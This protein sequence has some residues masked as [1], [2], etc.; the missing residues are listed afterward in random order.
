MTLAGTARGLTYYDLA[1]VGTGTAPY[2][3][4]AY[5]YTDCPGLGG[6]LIP[7]TQQTWASIPADGYIYILSADFSDSPI[8][9][10]NTLWMIVTFSSADAGWVVADR[11]ETGSTQ[12]LYGQKDPLWVC[13][14]WF[15]G[16]P[17]DYAGFWA[18]I[19]CIDLPEPQGAC[20][21]TDHTCTYGTIS[22]CTAAGGLFMGEGTTCAGVNCA[23]LNVGACCNTINWSC[24]L[25]TAADCAAAGGSFDG[26]GTS[27][28]GAC[29]E[30]R[31]EINPVTLSYNPGRPMAEDLTLAGTA[32]DLSYFSIAVYGGGG[33]AFNL[34]TAF[35]TA[36]PCSGGTMIPGT[37][38]SGSGLPDGQVLN[39]T[40]TLP[41][42]VT[43]PNNPWLVME[44]STAYA[45]WIVA[46]TAEVGSTANT[47]GLAQYDGQ[48]WTWTCNNTVSDAYGGF[49][50]DVQCIDASKSGRVGIGP[51]I[52]EVTPVPTPP[53]SVRLV[54]P[55]GENRPVPAA[56]LLTAP[57]RTSIRRAPD[58]VQVS[59][60]APRL[61]RSVARAPR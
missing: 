35:Y 5:L 20:C 47:F 26:V 60:S 39:L 38:V 37:L 52:L 23:S 53:N 21:R 16:P 25:Q 14:Y 57:P 11:A 49:W 45:G 7:G 55:P 18:D 15:G 30:Y 50:V 12:D 54:H 10:P 51:P 24:T 28:T 33:G 31:N 2:T 9:L 58:D 22:A 29:P 4:N 8:R 3:V 36:S 34:S 44:F 43:I 17:N 13:D 1:V 46:E 56:R 27:C 42:P 32:R 41:A 19:Q 59:P 48:Q 6:T 61:I 40:V